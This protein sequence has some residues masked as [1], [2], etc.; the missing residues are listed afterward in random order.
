MSTLTAALTELPQLNRT[1]RGHDFFGPELHAAPDLYDT[2]EIPAEEKTVHAHY[3]IGG[4]DWWVLET[5]K[6]SGIAFGFT[7][8][9]GDIDSAEFG[10]TSLLELESV[11]TQRG[12]VI[13]RDL[14]WEPVLFSTVDPR[15]R[16]V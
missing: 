5:D 12:F 2:E 13:E 7:I 6:E 15:N 4:C 14:Y 9:N 8:L 16:Q 11:V 3:F 10:Y 1:R